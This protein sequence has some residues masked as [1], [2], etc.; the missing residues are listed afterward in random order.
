MTSNKK[1][2]SLIE[3]VEIAKS[4]IIGTVIDLRISKPIYLL[5]L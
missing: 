5:K 4:G 3:K 1:A 2:K